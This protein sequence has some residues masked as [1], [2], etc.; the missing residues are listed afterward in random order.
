MIENSAEFKHQSVRDLAWVICSPPLVLQ[1]SHRCVWPENRWYQKIY[2]QTLPWLNRLDEDPAELDALLACQKD[3]RLGKYFETLWFFWLNN[4]PRYQLIDNNLQ[5]IIGGETLG[6]IDFIVLDQLTKQVMHWEVAIKFYLGVGDTSEMSHWHGPNLRD[7]LDLKVEHLLHRQSVITRDPRVIQWLKQRGI[8]IDGCAVI[9]KGRL[10]Y[11][12]RKRF[13]WDGVPDISSPAQCSAG[14]L[15]GWWLN[16]EQ[17]EQVFDDKQRFVPLINKGWLERI[18]TP[19]VK[20][21]YDKRGVFEMVSNKI[22]RLPVHLSLCDIGYI[23][24]RLFLAGL[25]WP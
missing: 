16:P 18:P 7:R 22:I 4:N 5:I 10:Y 15:R 2:Q 25:D 6:E 1:P 11:P 13:S 14:H 3:R 19:S 23:R 17:F 9:L 8:Q 21:R 20:K 12:W 24:D